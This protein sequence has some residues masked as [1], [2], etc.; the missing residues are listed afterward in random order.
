MARQR[1]VSHPRH[2][3]AGI[4]SRWLAD[5]TAA[6]R[7]SGASGNSVNLSQQSPWVCG[8]AR[9]APSTPPARTTSTHCT[10]AARM[11]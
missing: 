1:R 4:R 5:K 3:Q 7:T 6:T 8:G 9:P 10:A 2:N 11:A